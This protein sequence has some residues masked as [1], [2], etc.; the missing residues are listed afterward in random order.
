LEEPA[1]EKLLAT[2]ATL[3]AACGHP[4][5]TARLLGA[6]VNRAGAAVILDAQPE[7]RQCRAAEAMAREALGAAGYAAAWEAGH[8]LGAEEAG[9]EVAHVLAA[10]EA[11]ASPIPELDRHGLTPRE[12]EVVRLLAAGRSNR[13]VAAALFV[14]QSTAISHVRNILAKLG[15]DSRT[16][17][18][19]WAIRHGLD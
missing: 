3:A 1:A 14:S 17:V 7:G 8:R 19:A 9:A 16:A 18:A 5:A 2:V 6:A 4:E 10:A 13:E 15:L 12:V 11:L